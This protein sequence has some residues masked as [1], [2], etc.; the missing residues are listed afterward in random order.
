MSN[1][2]LVQIW[3]VGVDAARAT[4]AWSLLNKQERERISRFRQPQDQLRHAISRGALRSIL[5]DL[6]QCRPSEVHI[7]AGP[8]GKPEIPASPLHFNCSH[9]GGQVFVA[10]SQGLQVGVDVE[11]MDRRVALEGVMGELGSASEIAAFLAIEET[12][13]PHAFF[14]WWTRKEAYMKGLGY[15]LLGDVRGVTAWDGTDAPLRLGHWSIHSLEAPAGYRAALAVETAQEIDI[16]QRAY[17]W[18]D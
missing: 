13:R 18:P 6:L 9:S 10:V 16:Q 5:G 7:A 11:R 14:S 1:G 15:G 17:A 4:R 2:P 8:N 12:A 3:Q